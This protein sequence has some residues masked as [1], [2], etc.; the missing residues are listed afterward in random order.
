MEGEYARLPPKQYPP[1]A[2]RETAEG[3]FWRRFGAPELVQCAGAVTHLEYCA[4]APHALAATSSVRVQLFDGTTRKLRRTVGRFS[5]VAYSGSLRADGRLMVAG[6]ERPVVQVFDCGSRAVLRSLQ[7]HSAAVRCARFAPGAGAQH[8]FSAS[9]D[10]TCAWW[11]VT[12]GARVC[13]LSGHEDYARAACALPG[14]ADVWATGGYDHTVRLWDVRDAA[15]GSTMR[16]LHAAPVEALLALPSGGML[17]SAAGAHVYVWDLLAGGRLLRKIAAAQKTLTC[18][19][20]APLAG[21]ADEHAAGPRLV[22]GGLDGTARVF[23]LDTWSVTH[24]ARYPAPVTALALNPPCSQLAAGLADGTLVI[25][26]RREGGPGGAMAVGGAGGA[27]AGARRNTRSSRRVKRGLKR[28][29]KLTA[30]NFRYFLRGRQAK[31][32]ARAAASY[33]FHL[34]RFRH[35]AA[36]D[37]AL[38]TGRPEVVAAVLE[39]LAARGAVESAVAGRDERRAGELLSFL[40]RFAAR[41]RFAGALLGAAAA[42]AECYGAAAAASPACAEALRLLRERVDGEVRAQMGLLELQGMLEPLVS[43]GLA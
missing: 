4:A 34:R 5:D 10:K 18:L 17:V 42:A 38:S 32:S 2:R 39:E 20:Y 22:A 36:L 7:G 16:L 11:D 41:P 3:K 28:G 12:A 25:R 15:R 24:S 21:A 30:A 23:E 33:F 27:R 35:G 9:D 43:G 40:A 37:A 29:V 8:V 14:G 19:A 1:R 6:G 26:M 31:V 13:A